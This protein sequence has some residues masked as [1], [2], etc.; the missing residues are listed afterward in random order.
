MW[1][2]DTITR[3]RTANND[4]LHMRTVARFDK[5]LPMTAHESAQIAALTATLQAFIERY[6]RDQ[7][8]AREVRSAILKTQDAQADQLDKFRELQA[9][10]GG[11]IAAGGLLLS[12]IALPLAIFWQTIWARLTGGAG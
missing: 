3:E 10:A 12:V 4:P 11:M 9:K 8:D 5:V 6:E 2:A 1:Q 7:R